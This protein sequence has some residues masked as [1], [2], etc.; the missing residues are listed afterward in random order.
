[1]AYEIIPNTILFAAIAGMLGMFFRHVP[2]AVEAGIEQQQKQVDLTGNIPDA[3]K[4]EASK[5]Y[6]KDFPAI[7]LRSTTVVWKPVQKAGSVVGQKAW[8]FMLE[9]KDLKQGQILAS[10]FARMVTPTALRYT[11]SAV[12]TPMSDAEELVAA[13]RF[14][15]A[16]QKYFE[17]LK[18]FPHEYT[19]YEGLVKIYLQQK[20][21]DNLAET[22]EYLVRHVP[23]NDSYWAQYGNVLMSTRDYAKAITAFVK[24]VELN[25]LVPSRFANL[26][27]S[28]QAEGDH[29]HAKASFQKASELEPST[30]QYL[31]LLA[32]SM[33]QLDERE[34][35]IQRLQQA[36]EMLPENLEIRKKI[37]ALQSK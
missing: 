13:G 28:Y 32:D 1:M 8:Q 6:K 18:K 3:I 15:E 36:A 24:A 16:E 23:E 22:L 35:A 26:G 17:V 10:K 21:F 12:H 27:L 14:D 34:A 2:E 7:F 5:W 9:A 31:V 20:Q 33:V 4:A 37:F 25:P 11:N 19:A 29:E 30:I